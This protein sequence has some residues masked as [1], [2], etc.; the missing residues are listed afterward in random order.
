MY[1]KINFSELGN[2]YKEEL[3]KNVIPFWGKYSPD[4]KYGGFFHYF[5]RKWQI[6]STNKMMWIQGRLVWIFCKVYKEIEQKKEWLNIATN[7]LEFI[8]KY[9]TDRN[10]NWYFMLDRRGEPLIAPYSIFSDFFVVM[11][12]SEYSLITGEKRSLDIAIDTFWNIHKRRKNPKGKYNKKLDNN[13]YLNHSFHLI[14]LGVARDLYNIVHDSRILTLI[15]ESLDIIINK[16]LD[17][18]R[19]LVFETVYQDGSHPDTPEGRL[20]NPG[21]VAE[22]MWFVMNEACFRNDKSLINTAIDA[23]LKTLEFGWDKKYK[24]LFYFLD[25]EDRPLEQLEWNMK[26][27]WPQMEA[28]YALLLGYY[29][30]GRKELINWYQKFHDYVWNL[31][32]DKKYG[33]WLGYFDRRNKIVLDCKGAKFKSCFHTIR[34]LLYSWKILEKINEKY[35]NI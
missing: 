30:T 24:G 3:L 16:L 18:K 6:Y 33:G 25:S 29:L 17:K 23:L 20:I 35:A 13:K 12:F 34:F 7:G 1:P 26:L 9:G 15:D 32:P 19:K 10:G 11:G 27:W 8:R 5:D 4:K 22:S 28:M 31:F 21:H 14:R 2:L